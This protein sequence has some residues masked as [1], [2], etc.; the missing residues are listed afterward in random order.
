MYDS[1]A[2]LTIKIVSLS[3][4]NPNRISSILTI[5]WMKLSMICSINFRI[6]SVRFNISPLPLN[7]LIMMLTF[8]LQGIALSQIME[9]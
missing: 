3:F 8:Y 1:S 7:K 9:F 4:M 2:C 6:H 5:L